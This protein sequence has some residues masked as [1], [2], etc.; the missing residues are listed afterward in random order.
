MSKKRTYFPP[1]TAQQRKLLFETWEATGNITVACQKA[2]VSRG[3]F[4]YWK[5]RFESEGYRGL[6]A[7]RKKGPEKGSVGTPAEVRQK[8][9]EMQRMSPE[10]GKRRITD[11]LAKANNWVPIISANTVRSILEI[12]GM[13]KPDEKKSQK[14]GS[15]RSSV[16][17]KRQ[18]KR[19]M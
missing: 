12:A 10:W 16:Q 1:T 5:P 6:E 13:W 19:S 4:Y 9:I 15:S 2:H 7:Y 3:T 8:V 11:E 18:D 14:T 17:Q